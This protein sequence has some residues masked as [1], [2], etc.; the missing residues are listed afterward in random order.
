MTEELE[1]KSWGR[2]RD[3]QERDRI[4]TGRK[5]T[6]KEQKDGPGSSTKMEHLPLSEYFTFDPI[7]E[8]I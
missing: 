4:G 5:G 6:G 7:P 3:R 1:V 2:V 8:I